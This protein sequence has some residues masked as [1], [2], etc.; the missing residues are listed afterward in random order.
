MSEENTDPPPKLKLSRKPREETEAEETPAPKP[1]LKLRRPTAESESAPT[2]PSPTAPASPAAQDSSETGSPVPEGS[3]E[4]PQAAPNPAEGSPE[5]PEI[6]AKTPDVTPKAPQVAPEASK[7]PPR[8]PEGDSKPEGA[9]PPPAIPQAKDAPSSNSFD[10]K[11]P[12]AGTASSTGASNGGSTPPEQ[13]KAPTTGSE[14]RSKEA[15][16]EK[17]SKVSDSGNSHSPIMSIVIIFVL[18]AIFGGSG[19]G[20]WFVLRSP[21]DKAP[22]QRTFDTSNPSSGGQNSAQSSEQEP[23]PIQNPIE[24]AKANIAKVPTAATEEVLGSLP[25]SSPDEVDGPSESTGPIEETFETS[26][27]VAEATPQAAQAEENFE[28]VSLPPASQLDEAMI[29]RVSALLS[30]S[31]IGGVRQG[32]D[33]K[34]IL[35][36]NSYITGD[37][38][39][40]E[41]GL[42]FAGIRKGKLAFKDANGIIYLKSF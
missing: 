9:T 3:P 35:D 34:V 8:E 22:E 10:P 26:P 30:Q 14:D 5:P 36:G 42:R 7:V 11:N 29:D 24:K 13:P 6:T 41:T 27:P 31:H 20:L 37:L 21:A 25:G 16:E 2:P 32:A 38:V 1:E 23:G 33:P 18:L 19:F 17:I 28:P 15:L 39:D 40:P 4:P 12:F